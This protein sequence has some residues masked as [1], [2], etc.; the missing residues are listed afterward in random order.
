[1]L[2]FG[3]KSFKGTLQEV[4]KQNILIS[5]RYVDAWK[6]TDNRR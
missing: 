6:H 4:K 3:D 1:M 2:N 5:L